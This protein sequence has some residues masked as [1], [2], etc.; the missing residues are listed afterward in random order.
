MHMTQYTV[1]IWYNTQY[2]YGIIHSM[3][4]TQYTVLYQIEMC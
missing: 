3:H 4:M 1:Y 2:A